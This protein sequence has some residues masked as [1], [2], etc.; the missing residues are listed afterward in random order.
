[1]NHLFGTS[2]TAPASVTTAADKE[3][4]KDVE[5]ELNDQN[6]LKAPTV[7]KKKKKSKPAEAE[8]SIQKGP[9]SVPIIPDAG[10][11]RKSCLES[12][13]MIARSRFC[14][15]RFFLITL[16]PSISSTN[17]EC[18]NKSKNESENDSS[19]QSVASP[20]F[21]ERISKLTLLRRLCQVRMRCH[22]LE[23]TLFLLITV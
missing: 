15:S 16:S 10:G 22:Q 1:M 11:D 6:P 12:L 14:Y 7:K 8:D 9:E 5:T 20:I 17:S 2:E 21:G 13:E 3:V 18:R 19:T 23:R 4:V